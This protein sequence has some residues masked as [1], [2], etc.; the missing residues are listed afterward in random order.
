MHS[1]SIVL[2]T[3]FHPLKYLISQS[4]S[5]QHQKKGHLSAFNAAW[6]LVPDWQVE[7]FGDYLSTGIEWPEKQK[8][9]SELWVSGQKYLVNV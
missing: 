5:S 3:T 7:Y 1:L 4:H 2:G 8:L 9:S 6:L